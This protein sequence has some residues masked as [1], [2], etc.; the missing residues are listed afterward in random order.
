MPEEKI[1][2]RLKPYRGIWQRCA[3]KETERLAG[4]GTP[5]IISPHRVR[6]GVRDGNLRWVR[7]FN[8]TMREIEAEYRVIIDERDRLLANPFV[9]NE[10]E[11][12]MVFRITSG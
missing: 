5:E 8:E 4:L 11:D 12:S 9:L 7:L 6:V 10:A 3:R 2:L 1:N